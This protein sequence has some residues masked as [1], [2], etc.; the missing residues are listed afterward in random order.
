MLFAQKNQ[1][2]GE[3]FIMGNSKMRLHKSYFL[4]NFN[5]RKVNFITIDGIT[6]SGKSVLANL[7]KIRLKKNFDSISIL[8]KDFFLLTREKRIS[9][10]K[11]LKSNCLSQNKV[12]YDLKKLH[13]L[14]KFLNYGNKKNSLKLTNLYNRKTGKNN[15]SLNFKYSEKNLIILEG[16]YVSQDLKKIT[17]PLVNILVIEKIYESLAR[18]IERIRD[19]KI[20]IQHVVTEFTK[21]H[22]QSFKYHLNKSKFDIVFAD[23]DREFMP[24]LKGKKIQLDNIKIFLK[25]H[26]Y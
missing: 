8:S 9:F 20:S 14:L 25:K 17:K 15:L 23:Q 21:I 11:K 16:I 5:K 4:K 6:C 26:L 18:K 2:C 22:L 12:H 3:N 7:L 1:N 19:K 10:T 24:V 13:Y